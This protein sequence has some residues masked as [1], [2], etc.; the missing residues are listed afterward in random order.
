MRDG[1]STRRLRPWLAGVVLA[2]LVAVVYLPALDHGYVDYD[3]NLTVKN[4]PE[5]LAGLT[6]HGLAWACTTFHSYNWMPLTWASHMLDVTLFGPAPRGAHLTN[7]L[8]HAANAVLLL[9]LLARMTG[10]F[11]KSF[12]VALLFAA[13]PLHVES[14]AWV[15]ER[16]DL[17]STCFWFTA[18]LAYARYA[19][20][21]NLVR[22]GVPV[23]LALALALMAKPMPVT[24]PFLLLLLDLWPLGRFPR[25]ARA[26]GGSDWRGW[27]PLVLE[28]APLFALSAAS[29]AVTVA[30]QSAGAAIK[31]L[32]NYPIQVRVLN[33]LNSYVVYLGHTLWPAG[34]H[35]LYPFPRTS[36]LAG[37]AAGTLLLLATAAAIHGRAR[38]PFLPT[39]WF[40]YL[41]T[42][43]PVIGLVQAG[44]QA[45]ADRYT[46][47]PLTGIFIILA[48][49]GEELLARRRWGKI[50]AAALVAALVPALA[51]ASRVQVGYWRDNL[52]LF[53]RSLQ[54]DPHNAIVHNNYGATLLERGASEAAI[55][56]FR[57]A[58]ALSPAYSDPYL[59][60]GTALWNLQQRPAALAVLRQAVALRPGD[61][62]ALFRMGIAQISTGDFSGAN[63]TSASLL[64][65]DAGRA[66]QLLQS[67]AIARKAQAEPGAGGHP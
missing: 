2:A 57:E 56:H 27:I 20:A 29:A 10:A 6:A 43:L 15:S 58:V 9:A 1:V 62:N 11:W 47:V 65:I 46:Y 17:L 32:A 34:L 28:K 38:R 49:G 37:A 51:V 45:M 54:V 23:F 19:A 33:A 50:A 21:P 55:G 52:S 25:P 24:A 67:I 39:A 18:L 41:G 30:A 66:R 4:N 53:G 8:L 7:L 14:V 44:D 12:V 48:W 40:W 63:D 3:D 22:R 5:V 59:N 13:H 42:L 36:V 35:C 31:S 16:K 64:R 61:P 60:L 26:G